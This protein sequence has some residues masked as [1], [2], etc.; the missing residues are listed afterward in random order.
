MQL[1]F[2]CSM[3]MDTDGVPLK[4]AAASREVVEALAHSLYDRINATAIRMKMIDV[5][6][7]VCSQSG[8]HE[9]MVVFTEG[10][11]GDCHVHVRAPFSFIMLLTSFLVCQRW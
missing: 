10:R 5:E 7:M 4:I 2:E 1:H 9:L 3:T 6:A 11:Y 8:R